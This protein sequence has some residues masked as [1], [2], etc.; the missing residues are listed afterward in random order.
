[1]KIK[2]LKSVGSLITSGKNIINS[3]TYKGSIHKSRIETRYHFFDE[4]NFGELF[5]YKNKLYWVSNF[6]EA[7]EINNLKIAYFK[8]KTPVKKINKILIL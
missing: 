8:D 3:N 1:M 6:N 4:L 7:Q 5:I 2:K